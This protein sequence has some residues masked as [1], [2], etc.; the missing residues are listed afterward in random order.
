MA[1]PRSL[2]TRLTRKLALRRLFNRQRLRRGFKAFAGAKRRGSR[3]GPLVHKRAFGSKPSR[4]IGGFPIRQVV[5]FRVTDVFPFTTTADQVL[6]IDT[7]P[8][9]TPKNYVAVSA[10]DPQAWDVYK[11]GNTNVFSAPVNWAKWASLYQSFRVLGSKC[12]LQMFDPFPVNTS[13]AGGAVPTPSP[14]FMIGIVLDDSSA[15]TLPAT[16]NALVEQNNRKLIKWKNI[17]STSVNRIPMITMGYSPK[18]FLDVYDPATA[19]TNIST[20]TTG[21]SPNTLVNFYCFLAN[22]DNAT[23]TTL[24]G[25][26]VVDFMVEFFDLNLSQPVPT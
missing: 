12:T 10:T 8:S 23:A 9:A 13:G 1:V 19:G 15:A 7:T 6:A 22:Q 18:K 5:R 11:A 4:T 16:N 21:F 2:R 20:A 3:R 26:I 17:P 25:R 24:N 14:G